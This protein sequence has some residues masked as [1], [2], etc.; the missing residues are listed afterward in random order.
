MATRFVGRIQR[1]EDTAGDWYK[2]KRPRFRCE[3]S[4]ASTPDGV[5]VVAI[6]KPD[7]RSTKPTEDEAVSVVMSALRSEIAAEMTINGK[8]T[9]SDPIEPAIGSRLRVVFVEV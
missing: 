5:C 1:V 8:P 9:W 7:I 6:R 4:V 2:P 3:L